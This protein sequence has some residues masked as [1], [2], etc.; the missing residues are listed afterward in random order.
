VAPFHRLGALFSEMVGKFICS[1]GAPKAPRRPGTRALAL[2]VFCGFL[3]LPD[4]SRTECFERMSR[5]PMAGAAP[6]P[7]YR[8]SMLRTRALPVAAAPRPKVRRAEAVHAARKAPVAQKAVH[9]SARK[10]ARRRAAAPVVVARRQ[11][12]P[13]PVAARELATPLSYALIHATVCETG[14]VVGPLILAVARVTR[15]EPEGVAPR[16]EPGLEIFP[17]FEP[18][19]EG[20]TGLFPGTPP[21]FQPPIGQPPTPES[22]LTQPPVTEIPFVK[23]PLTPPTPVPPPVTPPAL[24]PP[25]LTPPTLS[26]PTTPNPPGLTLTFVAPPAQPPLRPPPPTTSIPE[27]GAW[28]LM[29]L[30]FGLLGARLRRRALRRSA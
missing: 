30:G 1:P 14:P 28:A 27:P 26:P 7:G 23:P 15:P 19:D 25:G 3:A 10:P 4:I 20:P 18:S 2:A 24:K 16:P 13:M 9:R 22:P 29:I 5:I 11:P 12:T 8:A 21:T 17:P 6:A